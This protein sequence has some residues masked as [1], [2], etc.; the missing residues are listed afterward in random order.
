MMRFSRLADYAVVLMTHLAAEPGQFHNAVDSAAATGLPVPT[1]S[2]IMATLAR[3]G[4][5]VSQR[6][7]KGGYVLPRPAG[8]ISVAEI[9][10]ALDGPIAITHCVKV[11]PS[12][13]DVEQSCPSRFSLGRINTAVRRALLDISLAEIAAPAAV[14]A[15]ITAHMGPP[16]QAARSAP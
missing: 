15:R 6:G 9:V 14:V 11:G 2:K 12:S 13:C 4:L 1:V 5:L 10:C 7:A 3:H 16:A 8:A